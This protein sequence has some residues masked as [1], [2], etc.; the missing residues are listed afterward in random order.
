MAIFGPK[1]LL[2]VMVTLLKLVP[3]LFLIVQVKVYVLL[4]A[5][6]VTLVFGSFTLSKITP[7]EGVTVQVPVSFNTVAFP[8]S[9]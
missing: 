8:C 3:H 5:N 1:E 4:G 7:A 2:V 6:P 9:L